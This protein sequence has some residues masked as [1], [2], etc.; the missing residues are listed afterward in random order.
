[1]TTQVLG[2]DAA[3]VARSASCIVA[4]GI[5]VY[6][7]ETVYGIGG[8]ALDA[9]VM[10]RIRTL[11]GNAADKPMLVLTD[12]WARVADWFRGVPDALQRLM[13]YEIELPI[14]LLVM[15][16]EKAPE[17]LVGPEGMIGVR[18]SSDSFCRALI[19]AAGTPLL[20]TSAN[21]SGKPSQVFFED[22]DPAIC[23]GV[24]LAVDAGRTL[25]GIPST[26]VRVADNS[27]RVVREGAVDAQMIHKIVG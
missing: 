1:M 3:G 20:S 17:V 18:R 26:V 16:S 27:V 22:L 14:T 21:V 5:L 15:A 24:D 4:G 9:G 13:D 8:N 6:P 25:T 12:E 10:D 23:E 2:V 19:E 7:T 11:K